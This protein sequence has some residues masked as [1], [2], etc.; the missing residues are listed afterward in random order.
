MCVG[1]DDPKA[2]PLLLAKSAD[3]VFARRGKR[4]AKWQFRVGYLIYRQ[5]FKLVTGKSMMVNYAVKSLRPQA[6]SILMN[7]KGSRLFVRGPS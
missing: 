7:W 4:H 1:E 3:V 2:L 6:S 5:I